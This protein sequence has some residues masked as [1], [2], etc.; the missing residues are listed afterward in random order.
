MVT[1]A[2]EQSE[3]LVE[4]LREAGA[5]PVAVPLVAFAAP[6][7]TSE[8]DQCLQYAAQF[9]WVLFTSQNAVRAV[10]ERCVALGRTMRRTFPETKLAAVGPATAEAVQGAGL[11]VDYVSRVHNGLALAHELAKEVRGKKVFLPRS[12]GANPDLLSALVGH[13]AEVAAVV[14]YKTTTAGGD[15][16]KLE[17]VSKGSV[18]AILFFSPSAVH[19]LREILGTEKLR[20]FARQAAFVAIGPVSARALKEEG[21][22]RV[23]TA[24]DTTVGA[25]VA[26]LGQFFSKAEQ[27]RPAGAKPR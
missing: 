15:A 27:G 6:D 17:E 8:L 10:Q 24:A 3:T 20:E 22:E 19:R 9:D 13:G 21:V 5:E 7:D 4:A 23:L 25:S 14:A 12:D 26:V 2:A 18:D 16:Q 1:R 11:K